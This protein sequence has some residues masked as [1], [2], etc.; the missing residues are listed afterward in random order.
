MNIHSGMIYNQLNKNQ[1][2]VNKSFEKISS[3]VRIN[4][5][6]DDSAG[7]SISE[8]MKSNLRTLNQSSRN[9]QDGISMLQT[10]E[11]HLDTGVSI[12]QRIRELAV[13][14]SSETLSTSDYESIQLEINESLESIDDIS[15]RAK[16]NG[17]TL[18]LGE[19]GIHIS[20]EKMSDVYFEIKSMQVVDIG[21]NDF[22]TGESKQVKDRASAIE[23]L[24]TV[25]SALKSVN[26]NRSHVG[27]ME[28][29]LQYNMDR[30]SVMYESTEKTL[31]FI[32]DTDIAK[33]MMSLTK[34]KIMRDASEM[35]LAQANSYNLRVLDLLR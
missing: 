22:F 3:G 21:L 16:F 19:T 18:L 6:S 31:S 24:N 28:K 33:E 17:K 35:M 20:D 13:Q 11:S 1:N 9:M 10:A 4:R 12:L 32:K 15:R 23:L 7:L 5:A 27:I 2:L 29:K 26:K 34:N 8:N 14:G 25:D 30:M